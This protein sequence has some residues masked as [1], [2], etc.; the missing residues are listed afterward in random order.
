MTPRMRKYLL[1]VGLYLVAMAILM[2]SLGCAAAPAEAQGP[3]QSVAVP[4]PEPTPLSVPLGTTSNQ[5]DDLLAM[6]YWDLL[7]MYKACQ[8]QQVKP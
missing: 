1:F 8:A 5:L 4:C 2:S 3:A 7:G 6:A